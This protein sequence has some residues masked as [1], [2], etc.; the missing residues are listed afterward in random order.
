MTG[1]G[2]LHGNGSRRSGEVQAVRRR[3]TEILKTKGTATVA[4]LAEQLDMAQVSVRHHLD[5]LV[6][7]D[8][9]Q[10]A[11]VRRQEGAGRPSQIYAL[12]PEATKLFP[13]RHDV[14]ARNMLTEM[15]ALLPADELRGVLLRLAERTSREAPPASPDQSVEERL[16]EVTAFLCSRGYEA[17]WQLQ[18]GSYQLHACNCPY[19]GVSDHHPELCSMDLA[20]IQKLLSRVLDDSLGCTYALSLSANA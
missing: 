14:L 11:G 16:D 1:N 13:R 10:V 20:I 3:I 17:S 2:T 6:G 18:D 8:L 19:A 5:I 15:K 9:V 4:E 7:E 12:T